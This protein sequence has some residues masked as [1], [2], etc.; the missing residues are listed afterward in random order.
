MKKSLIVIIFMIISGSVYSQHSGLGLGV[1]IGEPTGFN[2]KYW[3]N[4]DNALSFNLGYTLFSENS[5]VN[6]SVD[7]LYHSYELINIPEN[8]NS[9]PFFYG[10][11]ARLITSRNSPSSF[12]ARG[13]AGVAYFLKDIPVDI[14]IEL[15]PVFRLLPSTR[16]D[17]DAGIGAR[18]FF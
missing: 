5:Q 8:Q 13:I 18:Y 7:Y 11:G 10:F 14:F 6:L 3:I 4:A 1:R 17:F 16:L 15:A 9:I 2:A 12:G